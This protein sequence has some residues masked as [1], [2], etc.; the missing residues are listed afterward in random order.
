MSPDV[1][2]YDGGAGLCTCA[3]KHCPSSRWASQ[4]ASPSEVLTPEVVPNNPEPGPYCSG[5]CMLV[6]S[7]GQTQLGIKVVETDFI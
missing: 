3:L 4:T 5:D 6:C 7:Q 1:T 2:A